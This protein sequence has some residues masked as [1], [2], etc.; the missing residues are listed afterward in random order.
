[1][2]CQGRTNPPAWIIAKDWIQ[3]SPLPP[4]ISVLLK[5]FLLM[6]TSPSQTGISL[7]F[8][9]LCAVIS[10]CHSMEKWLTLP[11]LPHCAKWVGGCRSRACV[12]AAT[13]PT[14][15]AS[16]LLRH[17][18]QAHASLLPCWLW[19]R[20]RE[21]EGDGLPRHLAWLSVCLTLEVHLGPRPK[22]LTAH[23]STG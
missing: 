5:D 16:W 21:K 13:M 20:T 8:F 12:W 15:P 10:N 23:W 18:S 4:R 22:A 11:L 6:K 2:H 3:S 19:R 1:M 17:E 14:V 7:E 9:L